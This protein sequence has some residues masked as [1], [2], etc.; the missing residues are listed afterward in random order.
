MSGLHCHGDFVYC[1][2]LEEF[3]AFL[4]YWLDEELGVTKIQD[5]QVASEV[6]CG[7]D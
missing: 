5:W 4:E 2:A 6:T 3:W 7:F 1:M